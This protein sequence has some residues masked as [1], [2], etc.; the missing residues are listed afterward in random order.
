MIWD[1]IKSYH[2]SLYKRHSNKSESD[3]ISYLTNLNLPKGSEDQQTLCEGKLTRKEC[4]E[5]LLSIGSNKSPG[6]DGLS[7]EF[8][9]CFFDE[10][11]SHLLDALNLAFVQEQLSNCQR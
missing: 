3:G 4:L 5:A 1:N 8:Y 10:I 9:V 2:S 7:K 6:K 11:I